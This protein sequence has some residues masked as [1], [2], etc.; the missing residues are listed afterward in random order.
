M[1]RTGNI[2]FSYLIFVDIVKHLKI[3][4]RFFDSLRG[5]GFHPNPDLPCATTNSF[6]TF[7]SIVS[8]L[9][10]NSAEVN[11]LKSYKNPTNSG[12]VTLSWIW[13]SIKT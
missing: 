8:G 4:S 13:L 10:L 11:Y 9:T 6:Q 12:E 2:T 1:F 5:I 3:E 7:G